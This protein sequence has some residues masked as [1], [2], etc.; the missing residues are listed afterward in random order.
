MGAITKKTRSA[1]LVILIMGDM[2]ASGAPAQQTQF[3]QTRPLVLAARM[4]LPQ[5]VGGR[6][7]HFTL[8]TKHNRVIVSA[9]ANNTVEVVN[10]VGQR[11]MTT[12]SGMDEPQDPLY[13]PEVNKL[14]VANG[15][16]KVNIY[17]GDSYKL[18][19]ELEIG[20]DADLMAYDAKENKLYVGYGEGTG[21]IGIIDPKTNE[22][23]NTDFML[24]EHPERFRLEENGPR[25][26]VNLPVA[27]AI[28]VI[29]RHTREMKT[30]PYAAAKTNFAMALDEADHRLFVHFRNP[31]QLTIWDTDSGKVVA[32]LPGII[33]ID[34]IYYDAPRKRI[35]MTGAE[36]YIQVIQQKNPDNYEEIARIPTFVGA[37]TSGWFTSR[38][39]TGLVVAVPANSTQGAELWLYMVQD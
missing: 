17:E 36:G 20:D 16:G 18:I 24:P 3:K 38:P 10:M 15:G 28:G 7:D 32:T 30:W 19:K 23:V 29:D 35:Y 37:R 2:I 26:F 1:V 12:I 4:P 33:D 11:H 34:D 6:L 13:I 22:R 39:R 5:S 31:S 8:D 9:L 27:S 21:A 25:I 14:F